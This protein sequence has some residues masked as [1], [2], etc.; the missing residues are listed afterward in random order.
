MSGLR[1]FAAAAAL[2]LGRERIWFAKGAV[3]A[4]A[5]ETVTGALLAQAAA[6]ARLP[7]VVHP[8]ESMPGAGAAADSIELSGEN[9]RRRADHSRGRHLA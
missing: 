5:S 3:E 9:R 8:R 2:A 7:L 1:S 4:P 6:G